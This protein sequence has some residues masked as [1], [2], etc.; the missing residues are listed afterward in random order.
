MATEVVADG[1]KAPEA[2]LDDNKPKI[3]DEGERIDYTGCQVWKVS[4]TK[5]SAQ[6]IINKLAS[7]KRKL[8]V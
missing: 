7:E 5:S 1:D 4:T 6:R 3:A 8:A 2:A